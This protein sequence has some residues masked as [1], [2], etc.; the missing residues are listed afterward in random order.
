MRRLGVLLVSFCALA[1]PAG[2]PAAGQA[3]S[4]GTLVVENGAA[5]QGTPVITLVIRGAAIGQISGSG[6]IL[7]SD[8]TPDDA[9]SAEVTGADWRR[10]RADGTL[11]RGAGFK[12]RA[13]GGLYKIT[14]WGSGVDLVA[15]GYGTA[16]LTGSTEAPGRDGVY[17]LNGADFR[18]LPAM[19]TRPL[20]IGG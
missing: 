5:P 3:A 14:I 12:F 15:S 2:V 17:S 8:G 9:F 6:K 16:I 19:P 10:D 11:W 18:S 7:I 1:L 20:A 4:D 13:V